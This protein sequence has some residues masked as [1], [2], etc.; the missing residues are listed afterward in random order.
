MTVKQ[1]T[2]IMP[3]KTNTLVNPETQVNL[4]TPVRIAQLKLGMDWHADHFRVVRMSFDRL[5]GVPTG[6]SR[7]S[8]SAT[9]DV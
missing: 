1:T 2:S 3:M 6:L 5:D 8:F 7:H 9:E 4:E